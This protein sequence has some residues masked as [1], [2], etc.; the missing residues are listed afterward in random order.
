MYKMIKKKSDLD[1]PIDMRSEFENIL[2]E[3]GIDVLFVRNQKFVRCT[4]FDDV[5]KTGDPKCQKCF[6]NGYFASI[7]KIK[8]FKSSNGFGKFV[9]TDIGQI[10]QNASIF[11]MNY[12]M[13]PKERDMI[14][15]VTWKNGFPIDVLEVL[16]INAINEAR[17]DR[18]RVEYYGATVSSR[19]DLVNL[20]SKALRELPRAGQ[21]E[22]LKGGKY[23][24]AY[25][26]Q[27]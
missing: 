21:A 3:F 16:E 9:Q 5:N 18:G 25:K 19:T 11:Y 15:K 20:F 12:K 8:T 22:L 27:D 10:V 23:I 1:I 7:Q 13:L 2:E 4:C 6:G 14:L 26:T 24:W 17:G